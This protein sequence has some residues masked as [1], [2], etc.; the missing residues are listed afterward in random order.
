MDQ[1]PYSVLYFVCDAFILVILL[2]FWCA[3]Y[4]K[5][6]GLLG[7]IHS[8][9]GHYSDVIMGMMASHITGVWIVYS[10]LCSGADQR[11]I[12]ASRHWPL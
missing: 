5:S 9:P 4:A 12:K 8:I 10:T 7:Y 1:L 3:P 2:P 11:N 6:N